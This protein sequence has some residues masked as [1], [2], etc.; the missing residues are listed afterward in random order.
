M[1]TT[2]FD[3]QLIAK[4]ANIELETDFGLASGVSFHSNRV[5]KGDIFFAFAGENSHGIK[6]ASQALERGAKF[7]VSNIAHDKAILVTDPAQILMDLGHWARAQHSGNIIAVTGSAGKTSSKSFIASALAIPKSP[8][9]FNTPLALA[10]TLIETIIAKEQKQDL[11]LEL[12]IDHI[13]EMDI[14]LN[15]AKPDYAVLTLIAES[16]LSGL[17]SLEN[18]AKEKKKILNGPKMSFV[19]SD[20]E[21]FIRKSSNIKTYGIFPNNADYL[22]KI[23]KQ[24]SSGQI[25]EFEGLEF[26][27][28]VL[29]SAMAKAA[30]VALALAKELNYDLNKAAQRLAGLR[31]EPGRLEIRKHANYLILDDSYNSSPIAVKEA[32]KVLASLPKPHTVI[33]GD[34]LELGPNSAKYHQGLSKYMSNLKLITIGDNA[35]FISKDIP[36]AMHFDS[37]KSSQEYLKSL[38][39]EGSIL[40]KASRGMKFEKVLSILEAAP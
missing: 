29:S 17:K 30:T 6:Y 2:D 13:G 3:S 31:L 19:S 25:L 16:H 32:L 21:Q 14:L 40:I 15:L 10:K 9:N 24:D 36:K 4:I 7:I 12:G 39:K 27:I 5:K 1:T 23:I 33:L 38:K 26:K 34:M 20:A 11:V 37:I 18:I 28:P 8:G 22:S 35:Q